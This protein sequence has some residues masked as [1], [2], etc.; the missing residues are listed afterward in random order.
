MNVV[1]T[2]HQGFR[3]T[4]GDKSVD[5]VARKLKDGGLLCQVQQLPV[6][7]SLH[8]M[9]SA[10][11]VEGGCTVGCCCMQAHHTT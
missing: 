11:M 3:L 6:I 2:A 8:N 1:R 5:I 10:Q 7:E 9:L 4:L